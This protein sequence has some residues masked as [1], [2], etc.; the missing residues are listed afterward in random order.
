MLV[1]MVKSFLKFPFIIS[2]SIAKRLMHR[3]AREGRQEKNHESLN[4]FEF[5]SRSL[6]SSRLKGFLPRINT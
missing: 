1:G 5:P 2:D 6:R 4:V 3:K